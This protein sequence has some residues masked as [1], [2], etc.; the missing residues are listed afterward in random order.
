M[1][2]HFAIPGKVVSVNGSYVPAKKSKNRG[3]RGGTN[4]I[5][6]KDAENFKELVHRIGAYARSQSQWPRDLYAV[7]DVRLT[8]RMYNSKH[9]PAAGDKFIR[10]ALEG[11]F[12]VNDRIVRMG[13]GDPPIKDAGPARIGVDVELLETHPPAIAARRRREAEDRLAKRFARTPAKRMEI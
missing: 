1:T 8:I 7:A 10:D 5:L 6:T 9:D 4:L 13:P 2:V 11:V 3:K 12:Y